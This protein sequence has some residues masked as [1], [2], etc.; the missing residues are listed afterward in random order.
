M[1]L[2][3]SRF[4]METSRLEQAV[5]KN[6]A[7]TTDGGGAG[8]NSTPNVIIDPSQGNVQTLVLEVPV[9]A[10]AIG[11]LSFTGAAITLTVMLKQDS[12]GSRKVLWPASVQWPTNTIPTLSTGS[13]L[14]D[15]FSLLSVDNG[16]SWMGSTVTL[17]WQ[18]NRKLFTW[19]L[20]S[21]WGQL[22]D[23]TMVSKSSPVQIGTGLTWASI[24][25]GGGHSLA[26]QT[27]DT[28]WSFGYNG[29]YF[30]VGQLGDGTTINKSSPVKIGVLTTWATVS[31]G[32]WHSLA[33]KTDG[34]LWSFGNNNNYNMGAGGQLGDGTT[35][36]KSSP[37]KIGALTTWATVAGGTYHSL[38]VKTD[39][40]LWSFG[41]NKTGYLG[42]GTTINK[43]SPVKIGALTTWMSVAAG[44]ASASH[45]LAIQTNGT[46]WVWG[47]N[48]NGRLGDGTTLSKSSPVQI[49]SLTS[50]AS[51]SA[52]GTHSLAIQT[53]GTL[54]AWGANTNG[55]LGDGTTVSK[56]SPVQIGN[57][58]TWAS[59]S[60]GGTHSLAI[61]TNGTLWAWGANTNGRLGDGTTLSKSS[62]V[63]IGSLTTWVSVAAGYDW[64][65]ALR[66]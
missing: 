57:L 1:K 2:S 15:V 3:S 28:F 39:G 36:N 25:G 11:R 61:Q 9:T 46:L 5:L 32:A 50:W 35:I 43:S 8:F 23:G 7:K 21:N 33:V 51:V 41:Y 62:P 19:G 47:A 56:S 66:G 63:Q 17:G 13:W 44:K 37:V 30:S 49:D 26:T 6:Y 54:W 38:A 29:F 34:T 64:G 45:S 60:A 52:G 20:N 18:S 65:L 22:G 55:R 24:T 12:A 4:D 53:N 58:T 10:L 27:N 59:V 31:A 48:T 42:D 14:V 40:T 16:A